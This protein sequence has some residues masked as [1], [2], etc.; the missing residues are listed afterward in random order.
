MVTKD[1]AITLIKRFVT[2]TKTQFG[3]TVRIVR[4]DKALELGRSTEALNFF[5]EAR[6]KY[7]TSCDHTPQ[8]NGV[9]ERKHKHLLE[10]S[11]ALLFQS[12]LALKY[13]GECVLTA[14]YLIN[15]MPTKVLKGK[16]PFE[17]LFGQ[18]PA[19]DHLRVFGCLCFM[20]TSK[21]GKDRFHDRAKACV[22]MGYPFGK[23][24]YR[25]ME[26]ETSKFHESRDVI[27]HENIFPSLL[28]I[29][30]GSILSF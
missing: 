24:G 18:V 21:H 23:K 26:L 20:T 19:Y 3:K 2:M 9:V 4:S 16:T 27:F 14:T 13:W 10:V 29:K 17:I 1:E 25:V 5:V 8:Q 22:F 15:R 28:L 7:E 12:S 11:K 6:I 30:T